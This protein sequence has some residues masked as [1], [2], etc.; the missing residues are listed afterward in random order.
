ME[1][2]LDIKDYL[3]RKIKNGMI[4]VDELDNNWIVVSKDEMLAELQNDREIEGYFLNG[5]ISA[6]KVSALK[7]MKKHIRG[8]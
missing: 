5:V 2:I 3:R 4:L 1:L 6:Y 8:G 7:Y